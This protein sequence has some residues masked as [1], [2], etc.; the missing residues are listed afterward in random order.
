MR[1]L[2]A[3]DSQVTRRLLEAALRKW[4]FLVT[5]VEDGAQASAVLTGD[6]P[7]AI[8]MLDW[9]MPGLTGI[10]VC[11]RVRALASPT[12]PYIMVVTS[13]EKTE[14]IV[15]ALEA[16]ADD[17][18]TKP[19]HLDELKA[20]VEVG[21]RVVTLQRKLADRI[22]ELEHALAHVTRL[23]GLLPICMYCK[24]IR[25]DQGYWQQV[26]GY[27]SEHSGASFSHSICPDCRKKH[28]DPQIEQMRRRRGLPSDDA[29]E[30]SA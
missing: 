15:T 12:P 10:E 6:D 18:V 30:E 17:C 26:E 16:G 29:G 28:V 5:A 25:K 23:Q 21:R 14:D 27:I 1:V 11:G 13:K 2:V 3:E 22:I 9:M 19:F 4:G 8:A 20:R 7:P 24:S